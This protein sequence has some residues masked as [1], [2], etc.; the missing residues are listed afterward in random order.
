M[1]ALQ[2]HIPFNRI[3]WKVINSDIKC[4]RFPN[5]KTPPEILFSSLLLILPNF[6]IT[7]L[8]DEYLQKLMAVLKL[9][10]TATSV[11]RKEGIVEVDDVKNANVTLKQLKNAYK[12]FAANECRS[13][14]I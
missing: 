6:D 9:I 10:P 7:E 12:N 8:D 4:F 13:I 14:S 11:L 3:N 5:D 2:N 1:F